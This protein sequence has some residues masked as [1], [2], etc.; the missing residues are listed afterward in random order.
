MKKA[1]RSRAAAL[2]SPRETL[3]GYI[4][5][6]RLI[7]KVRLHAKGELPPEYHGNLLKT[8]R[9]LDGWLLSFTGLDPERLRAAILAARGDD[10]V[11]AWIDRHALSHTDEQKRAWAESIAGYRPDAAGLEFRTKSYPDLSARIDIGS[12]GPLD[13]IDMDEGRMPVPPRER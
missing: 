10:E 2:R 1:D 13:M 6:P 3:G 12:L 11:L 7:D 5:L 4:I 9:T 8:G